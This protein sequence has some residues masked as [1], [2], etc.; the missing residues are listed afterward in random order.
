[1]FVPSIESQQG[2]IACTVEREKCSFNSVDKR[3]KFLWLDNIF[4]PGAL[5]INKSLAQP[6]QARGT[7]SLGKIKW[8]SA[9]A[10]SI[11]LELSRVIP[12][13]PS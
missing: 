9:L 1:M 10:V 7:S 3:E 11:I 6:F 8:C 4:L 12:R 5:S 13:V 2:V